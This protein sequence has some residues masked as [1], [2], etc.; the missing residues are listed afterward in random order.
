[1]PEIHLNIPGVPNTQQ[2]HRH[3]RMGNFIRT[4]DPSAP[5]KEDFLYKAIYEC[6][7]EIPII[8]PVSIVM[9]FYM[10]RPKSHFGT[11]KN[12][13]KLKKNAPFRHSKKPDCD[14]LLKFCLDA[15]NKIYWKDDAQIYSIRVKKMYNDNPRTEIKISWEQL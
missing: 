6:K 2:R 3:V 5:D 10:P 9:D 15:L 11:G 7:P 14:N 4:Y 13:G 1:M 12:A 8:S